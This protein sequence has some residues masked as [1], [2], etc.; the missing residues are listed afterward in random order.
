M[1][2]RRFLI[3]ITITI[4]S[5]RQGQW[6]NIRKCFSNARVTIV[7]DNHKESD[8]YDTLSAFCQDSAHETYARDDPKS[9]GGVRGNNVRNP[10][11]CESVHSYQLV[12]QGRDADQ[13]IS[14]GR[15][16]ALAIAKSFVSE[17][18]DIMRI[19][20]IA[21][22]SVSNNQQRDTTKTETGSSKRK[23]TSSTTTSSSSS[24]SSSSLTPL[25]SSHPNV[26]NLDILATQHREPPKLF[27]CLTTRSLV[28]YI[29]YQPVDQLYRLLCNQEDIYE[30]QMD[31]FIRLY[32]PRE[33]S[34]MCLII[35]C[36]PIAARGARLMSST[37]N[38]DVDDN[39]DDQDQTGGSSLN[40]NETQ[41]KRRAEETFLKMNDLK[42]SSNGN[43]QIGNRNVNQR[44][45]GNGGRGSPVRGR[46]QGVRMAVQKKFSGRYY[47]MRLFFSRIVRPLWKW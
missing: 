27:L 44:A 23:A 25:R 33:T 42:K 21:N 3:F 8:T 28:K 41:A 18:D 10:G 15:V 34:A 35:I 47:G 20:P 36:A 43:T 11:L 6:N 40:S 38:V 2:L 37:L 5:G 13:S 7:V 12:Q 30:E 22:Q 1:L 9:N 45:L 17:I 19:R 29:L 46:G 39:D 32:G 24:S 16:E 31:Q 14:I 26:I 4:R